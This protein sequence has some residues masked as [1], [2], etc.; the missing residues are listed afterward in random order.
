MT[1]IKSIELRKYL[2][3]SLYLKYINWDILRGVFDGDGCLTYDS[4]KNGSW[5]FSIT[6]ASDVFIQQI[7]NFLQSY[8]LHPLV[9]KEGN[10]YI[11]H[12]GKLSEI[13]FIFQHLYKDS[14]YFL[15]RKYEKFCPLVEKFTRQDFVNS[16]KGRENHKTEPSPCREG[17]ET[18]NETPTEI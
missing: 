11:I 5:R 17:A 10:Y 15:K 8:D 9:Y 7:S 1:D 18:L 3:F 4:R 6:S 14:S 16:V 12:I 2:C 13:Y